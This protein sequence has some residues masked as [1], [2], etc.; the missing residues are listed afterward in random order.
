MIALAAVAFV[1]GAI[2]GAGH[3]S[4]AAQA[5]AG[6]FVAAWAHGDYGTMYD[7]IDA[8]SRRAI[9][10]QELADD[11][12]HALSTATATHLQ[13]TGKPRAAPGGLV[14]VPVR[15]RTRLFGTLRLA[16]A[17][18][19]AGGVAKRAESCGRARWSSPACARA[20]CSPAR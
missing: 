3:G 12:Q 16:F 2:V 9:S 4:S 1:L 19:I 6:R 15:V 20:R 13:V 7:D 11:Y 14:A 5:L 17:L 18:K 8:H 10:A